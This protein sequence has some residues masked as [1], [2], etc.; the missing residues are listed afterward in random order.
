G[1]DSAATRAVL[2]RQVAAIPDAL[3]DP[4]YAITD[5]ALAA[6][7]RS[8]V[9]VPLL[10]ER[11]PIG[12]INVGRPELGPF[13]ERHIAMLETFADQAVIA[14]ASARLFTE[15]E[16]RNRDV[17]ESLAQQTATSQILR[18]ISGSRRDVQPVFDII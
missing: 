15:L 18:L 7:F 6:G 17:T 1:R 10:H 13:S 9:S 11:R 5:P 3:L 4:E 16:A 8:T 14:T 12:A 2:T